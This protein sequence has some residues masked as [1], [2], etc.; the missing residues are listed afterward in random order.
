MF[1]LAM[2]RDAYE[3]I[4]PLD[5]QFGIGMFEDDDYAMRARAAGYRVVCAQDCFVHH[6]GKA[7]FGVL[8]AN[9][10][11]GDLF[12]TNRRRFEAKWNL[13]WQPHKLRPDVEYEQM[14]QRVRE[15]IMAHTPAGATVLCLSKGDDRLLHLPERIGGHFPQD[16]DGGYSGFHPGSDAEALAALRE[17]E[18][19]FLVIPASS[20]WWLDHYAAFAA[21]LQPHRVHAD[22]DCSIYALTAEPAVTG[23]KA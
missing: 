5:Q 11:Y 12:H 2:R 23:G 14:V 9:G 21:H 13:T 20:A 4:G 15:R 16:R 17:V 7:S 22:A 1:C 18:G 10:T 3:R 19:D 6:F 8:A